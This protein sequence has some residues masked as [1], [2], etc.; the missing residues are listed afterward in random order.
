[1]R[2]R[3]GD[4]IPVDGV[5]TEGQTSVDESM[6]TGEP[7]PVAKL[8]G[9]KVIGGTVNGTGTI[10]I[11]AEKVGADT[12]LAQIVNMVA[13]AQ[14]SRA[15]IQRLADTVAGY[16]VP[17]VVATSILTF[18]VWLMLELTRSWQYAVRSEVRPADVRGRE[19]VAGDVRSRVRS[20]GGSTLCAEGQVRLL[21]RCPS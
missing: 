9:E 10:L 19:R 14:R 6:V 4:K 11:Q 3:P 1:L 18:L 12:L 5:V 16:F 8:A 21:V 2:V 7:M 13:E 20:R 15:P 17:A